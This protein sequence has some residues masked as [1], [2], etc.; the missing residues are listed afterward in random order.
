MIV[1]VQSFGVSSNM[2]VGFADGVLSDD[3]N[4]AAFAVRQLISDD[5]RAGGACIFWLL[6]G[7]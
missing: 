6:R 3:N 7:S 5:T 2:A 1:Q 4:S